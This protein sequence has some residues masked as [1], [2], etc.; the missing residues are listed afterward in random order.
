MT[1]QLPTGY[2]KTIAAAAAYAA[3]VGSGVVNRLLYVV[4][5]DP[6]RQQFCNDGYSDFGR[7][8]LMKISPFDLSYNH[9]LAIKEH[10]NDKSS[11]SCTS[12]QAL[13]QGNTL[14]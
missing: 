14:Q 6:Q 10:R 12:V 8:G 1:A 5:T 2:G 13:I 3:L 7:V 9:T 11:V 4:S